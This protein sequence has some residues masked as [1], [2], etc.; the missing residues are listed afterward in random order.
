MLCK[1]KM[2]FLCLR[3]KQNWNCID[4]KWFTMRPCC[5]PA[6]WSYGIH[7][8]ELE[9]VS[10]T[11]LRGIT[12]SAWQELHSHW[13]LSLLPP[14]ATFAR[15]MPVCMCMYVTAQSL[16][17]NTASKQSQITA[18]GS[19][20]GH[21]SGKNRNDGVKNHAGVK[22]LWDKC[23]EVID[24]RGLCVKGLPVNAFPFSLSKVS[25]T[26][27]CICLWLKRSLDCS[28]QA[29]ADDRSVS[30]HMVGKMHRK[31]TAASFTVT[32]VLHGPLSSRNEHVCV[33]AR[34]CGV[35][36]ST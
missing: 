8:S 24:G 22:Q 17:W 7:C 2:L 26:Q 31:I 11:F 15:T 1:F 35:H 30:R 5:E 27:T 10:T 36:I 6:V 20:T 34:G 28:V 16:T 25:V 32:L 33:H 29:Q 21:D 12:P 14:T 3:K 19:Q 9:A 18:I 23:D 4:V 13:P